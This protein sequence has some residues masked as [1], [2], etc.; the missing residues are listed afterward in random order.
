MSQLYFLPLKDAEIR[1]KELEY[2][3]LVKD[4]E[5]LME[6]KVGLD[7]EILAYKKMIEGEEERLGMS[8][9]DSQLSSP[10][11]TPAG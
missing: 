11:T 9:S 1:A 5:E 6:T 7:M 8:A 4:F 10:Y 2:E 3:D